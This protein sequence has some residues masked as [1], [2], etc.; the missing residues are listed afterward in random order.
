MTHFESSSLLRYVPSRLLP[1][2]VDCYRDSDGY[3]F[4]F[5]DHVVDHSTG[6]HTVHEDTIRQCLQAFRYA[7]VR[8]A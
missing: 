5:S 3:W 1:F 4:H 2:L 6:S 7:E 8:H